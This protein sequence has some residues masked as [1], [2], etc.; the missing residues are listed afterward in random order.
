MAAPSFSKFGFVKSY[1]LPVL[2]TF[3]IPVLGL[4]FYSYAE[5]NYDSRARESILRDIETD[6]D[7]SAEEKRETK[8]NLSKVR[9][10]R[11]LA[12]SDPALVPLQK[13]VSSEAWR[14]YA[15]FRWMRRTAAL[16]ILIG[17][18]AAV[19]VG[20]AVA[21]S[22]RSQRVQYWSL[23]VGWHILRLTG[24][25]QVVG[26]GVL[27]ATMS[28]WVSALLAEM[29][30]IKLIAICAIGAVVAV[31]VLIAAIFKP[32]P[33]P[34][35]LEGQPVSPAEAPE[36][37]SR[38]GEMARTLGIPGP[39]H[40]VVGI[41][42]MRRPRLAQ[43]GACHAGTQVIGKT[44]VEPPC[45]VDGFQHAF[46]AEQ[47][48]L[49]LDAI[50][51]VGGDLDQGTGHVLRRS[52]LGRDAVGAEFA[53]AADLAERQLEQVPEEEHKVEYGA[54]NAAL[55]ECFQVVHILLKQR[56]RLAPVKRV[57]AAEVG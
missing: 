32:L 20:I 55:I 13:G 24:L 18:L 14:D 10:S 7:L 29:I 43:F 22:F 48:L 16:C 21:V 42:R 30:S 41:E 40:I 36:L 31:G 54:R 57:L 56:G 8:E 38:V 37:W 5:R 51:A 23:R 35:L 49:H 27:I 34:S 28:Y 39:D 45:D 44:G 9:L 2:I 46:C 17:I 53:L 25:F 1:V 11:I 50:L 19:A 26:Q 4:L 12:S 47:I 6:S 15:I 33:G 3:L 52:K